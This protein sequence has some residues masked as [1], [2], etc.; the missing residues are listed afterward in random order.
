M[1]R[2]MKYVMNAD[3]LKFLIFPDTL[4]HSE[5]AGKWTSAGFVNFYLKKEGDLEHPF[6]QVRCYGESVSLKLK[7]GVEDEDIINSALLHSQ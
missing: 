2:E 1:M 7:M 6:I 3:T 4:Q 5:V